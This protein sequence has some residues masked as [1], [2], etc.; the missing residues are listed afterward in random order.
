MTK[1]ELNQEISQKTNID[2][3][4]TAIITE[5]LFETIKKEIVEGNKITF[6][7]FG[8]FSQKKRSAKKVQLIKERKTISL[9]EYMIPT[10]SPSESFKKQVV[11]S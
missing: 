6:K 1:A 4:E 3:N 9:S 10:F 5:S 8:T 7:G 2:F 11:Q